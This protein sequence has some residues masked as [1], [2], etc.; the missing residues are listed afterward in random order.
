MSRDPSALHP[1]RV[2]EAA[3]GRSMA[4]LAERLRERGIPHRMFEEQGR[5]VVIAGAHQAGQIRELHELV[6]RQAW[7]R[8]QPGPG[9]DLLAV[10][11]F[12]LAL[13]AAP[14][15]AVW[16]APAILVYLGLV[17]GLLPIDPFWF[18]P[19]EAVGPGYG[20]LFESL[21]AGHL[22]RLWSP[23]L[24]HFALF[25]LAFNLLWLWL[26]GRRIEL[27]YG[28]WV[29][30]FLILGSGVA[31]N[32]AQ[33]LIAPETPWFGGYSGVVYA[34]LGFLLWV[35][36]RNADPRLQVPAGLSIAL[37]G[38]M[39]LFSM[40]IFDAVLGAASIGVANGAHW[41]GFVAGLAA[42]A[43]IETK[44]IPRA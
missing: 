5:V 34:L 24:L 11:G 41:G 39:V 42:G 16:G 2:L 29:L 21:L 7:R 43:L 17:L 14:A 12:W 22:W 27:V 26:L 8:P 23:T 19:P 25:H 40:G 9:A 20:G 44:A 32:L 33:Y 35:A 38:V 1:V 28:P 36:P 6:E 4:L 37:I 31:A 18:V 30:S 3:P 10:D 13:R 15:T